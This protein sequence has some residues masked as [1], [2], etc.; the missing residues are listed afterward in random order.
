[1]GAGGISSAV[2]LFV[3]AVFVLVASLREPPVD[4]EAE[5][6]ALMRSI[7]WTTDTFDPD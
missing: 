6:R 1:V 5:E 7:S 3:V 2:S 4:P